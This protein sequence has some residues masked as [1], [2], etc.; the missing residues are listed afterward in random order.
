LENI[1]W[2]LDYATIKY[3]SQG[4]ELWVARYN[5]PGNNIDEANA[6]A[7]DEAG[8][9]YVTG[10]SRGDRGNGIREDYATI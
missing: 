2:R 4:N 10:V 3:D 8:N 5:G 1:I 6:I 9:I 7:L